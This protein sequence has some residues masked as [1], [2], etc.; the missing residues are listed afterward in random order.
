MLEL[1]GRS[2]MPVQ[3][4][5]GQAIAILALLGL[6]ALGAAVYL[7]GELLIGRGADLTLRATGHEPPRKTVART[8]IDQ[9]EDRIRGR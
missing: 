9:L 7:V 2:A 3:V 8:A 4:G 6:L 1:I 5:R